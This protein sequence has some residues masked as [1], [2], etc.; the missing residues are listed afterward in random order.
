MEFSG[1]PTRSHAKVLISSRNRAYL[2]SRGQY[3]IQ[4]PPRGGVD[5][6][7]FRSHPPHL[8]PNQT[9]LTCYII[10]NVAIEPLVS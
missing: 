4:N 7:D 6:P 2:G 9:L 8:S 3:V 5:P 1:P 10:P